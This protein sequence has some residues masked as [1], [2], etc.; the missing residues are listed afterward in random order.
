VKTTALVSLFVLAV[1]GAWLWTPDKSRAALERLYLNAATD[2]VEA[3]GIRLHVRDSGQK[4]APA[5]IM[6]HGMGASLHTWDAWAEKLSATH[7]IIRFDLPGCGLT[8]ADPTGNYTNERRIAVLAA[9][10]DKLGVQRASLIGN[11]MGG[12]LAWTFAA[13]NPARVSR[14]VLISPDGFASPGFDY[15]RPPAVPGILKVMRFVLPKSLLRQNLSVAYADPNR[16][17]DAV[18]TR[19]H[20]LLRAPGVRGAMLAQMGQSV[21]VPPE[22]LL[23][24]ITVPSLLLW[25]ERD[26]M[27]PVA[28]AKDYSRALPHATLV[29]LPALGHV[30]HEEDPATSLPPVQAFLASTIQ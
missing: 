28:N 12:R 23:R 18:V 27:I 8:G 15:G 3:A 7:R 5:I 2:Y 26:G 16:L 29:I 4:Q 19:Y 30:P 11:S 22:P 25:G 1:A 20:D 10:M 6:L 14:L 17:S 9:L 24:Q 13:A 21:L